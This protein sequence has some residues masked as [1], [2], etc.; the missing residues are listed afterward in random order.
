MG[1][2]RAAGGSWDD[3]KTVRAAIVGT[4]NIAG[5]HVAALRRMGGRAEV[6]AA[7]DVDG[8]RAGAFCSE[9]GIPRSY[10]DIAEM[11]AEVAPDLVH[12]CT[13]PQSHRALSV[14]CMEAGAWVLCE[15]PLCGSLEEMDAIEHAE[16]ATGKFCA[17]VYQW[18]FGSGARHLKALISSGELGRP[19]AGL[20]QTTWYRDAAYY[21][22][23]WRGK[24]ETELGGATMG[25]GIHA[26]DLFLWLMGDWREV[27]AMV[28]TLDRN[29]EVEDVSMATVLLENG[30][31]GSVVNSVL[32][33]RQRTH[34]RF[35]LQEATVEVDS[36]YGYT[37]A[38]WS[39]SIPDGASTAD[40]L[41]RWRK[42]PEESLSMHAGQV[43]DLLDCMQEDRRPSTSGTEARRTLEFIT[44]LYKA[45]MTG[46]PVLRGSIEKGD[47]FYHRLNGE[48]GT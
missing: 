5:A 44:G 16:R 14:Q 3:V 23:P 27:R 15:K 12:V 10:V 35:D 11:L 30:A 20:C 41:A 1:E 38:D 46:E 31:M 2:R 6:V 47:P 40:S 43:A 4:G 29:I 45:A 8:A 17:S 32:S 26:M 37:N 19:L 9:H 39:Y 21:Q 42:I 7:V 28:G 34:L 25:Q 36:L 13:P 22:V 48:E 18:R 24:W 33:P